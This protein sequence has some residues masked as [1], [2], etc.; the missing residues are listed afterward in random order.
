VTNTEFELGGINHLAL[1]SS[2]MQQTI[3]FYSGVL[4]M[5]LIKTIEL[6]NGAALLL[7]LRRRRLPGV[8]L[9]P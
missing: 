4:G 9:V 6:P 3:D 7:R 8:L 1:V 2:D 5:P